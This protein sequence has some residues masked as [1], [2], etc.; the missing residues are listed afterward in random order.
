MN[1]FTY[2]ISF[3]VVYWV[4]NWGFYVKIITLKFGFLRMAT[5]PAWN[6]IIHAISD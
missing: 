6:S 1:V 3:V 5:I 2:D 4:L